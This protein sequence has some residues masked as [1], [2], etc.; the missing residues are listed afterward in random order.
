MNGD[1]KV[2]MVHADHSCGIQDDDKIV[3]EACGYVIEFSN[4]VKIY[5]AGDANGFGDMAIIRG[6][7]APEIAMIPIGDHYTMSPREAAYACCCSQRSSFPCPSA[8]EGQTG[9]FQKGA[10]GVA[11]IEMKPGVTIS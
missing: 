1:I 7:Y 10:P 6:L 9:R 8:P 5:H 3:G 11:V 4:S 2:I